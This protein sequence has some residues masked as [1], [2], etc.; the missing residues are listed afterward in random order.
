MPRY[1][2]YAYADGAD[3]K[4]IAEAVEARFRQFVSERHWTAG[5]PTVV[6]RYHGATVVTETG[7][8]DL[9]HLGLTVGLPEIGTEFPK[10]FVD[11]EAIAR[12]L[13]VLHREFGKSFSLGFLDCET[14]RHVE[15]FDVSALPVIEGVRYVV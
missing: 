5:H 11:V 12:F 7:F 10:W 14:G 13:G 2:L 4:D 8:A 1:T 6:N 3:F 15:L 9:W